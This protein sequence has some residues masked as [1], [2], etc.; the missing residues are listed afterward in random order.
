[1]PDVRQVARYTWD[2]CEQE[3]AET[4]VIGAVEVIPRAAG[5]GGGL[6]PKGRGKRIPVIKS[7]RAQREVFAHLALGDEGGDVVVLQAPPGAGHRCRQVRADCKH[8]GIRPLPA[9][10]AGAP[11]RRAGAGLRVAEAD[12]TLGCAGVVGGRGLA[13]RALRQGVAWGPCR[14]AGRVGRAGGQL[15]EREQRLAGGRSL[16][17]AAVQLAEAAGR[18]ERAPAGLHGQR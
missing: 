1:V 3:R 15:G 14:C 11:C 9:L 2:V 4:A 16:A 18:G 10:Q 13:E 8:R 7:P 12:G 6:K 5:P 17:V